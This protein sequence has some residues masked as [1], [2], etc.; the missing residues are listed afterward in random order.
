M[1]PSNRPEIVVIGGSWGGM[2][3]LIELLRGLAPDFELP[4]IAVLHRAP[5]S[6]DGVLERHVAAKTSLTVVEADDK[7]TIER[8]TVYVAP[9]DYHLIVEPGSL[10]LSVDAPVRMSRPSIDVTFESAADAYGAGVVAVVL[11]GANDDGAIGA[12]AVHA[13][14]GTVLVQEPSSATRREMPDAAVAS[15][16]ADRVLPLHAIAAYL[17][18]MTE[19]AS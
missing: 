17:S 4:V 11:T 8:G 7:V 5:S 16:A 9:A 19:P 1:S 13:A 12:R 3:A 6:G 18:S 10:A 14:G 2:D 15:G